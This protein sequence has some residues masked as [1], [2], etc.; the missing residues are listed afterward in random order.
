LS[1]TK[2]LGDREFVRWGF[3]VRREDWLR[4]RAY[5]KAV[6]AQLESGPFLAAF[7]AGLA[8]LIVVL[9]SHILY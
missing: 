8:L 5:R 9:M 1:V 4:R 3:I 7:D 2:D 6:R